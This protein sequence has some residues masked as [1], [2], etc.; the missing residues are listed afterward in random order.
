MSAV[1]VESACNLAAAMSHPQIEL[2]NHH[3]KEY[4]YGDTTTAT[5]LHVWDQYLF[6]WIRHAMISSCYPQ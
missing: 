3:G 2:V 6:G 5:V 4:G 1:A